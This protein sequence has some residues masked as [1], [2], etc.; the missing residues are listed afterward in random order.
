[1]LLTVYNKGLFMEEES[2]KPSLNS[3]L[4][5]YLYLLW[6]TVIIS[7]TMKKQLKIVQPKI[8]SL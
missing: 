6:N 8:P 5:I 1:M 2:P 3:K 7:T 4:Q